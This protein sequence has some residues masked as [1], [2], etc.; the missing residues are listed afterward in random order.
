MLTAE[1]LRERVLGDGVDVPGL[2]FCNASWVDEADLGIGELGVP[3]VITRECFGFP[4]CD[5]V[6]VLIFNGVLVL[7]SCVG[8]T[9]EHL[10]C[11]KPHR[12]N[13][14]DSS[15]IFGRLS[16]SAARNHVAWLFVNCAQ[17]GSQTPPI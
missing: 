15:N 8:Q 6:L 1:E 11:C 2:G 5:G 4:F 9:G 16:V 12:E 3:G 14:Q 7:E 17:V 13:G 10:S